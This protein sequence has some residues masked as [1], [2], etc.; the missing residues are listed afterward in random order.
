MGTARANCVEEKKQGL[1][2]VSKDN[3]LLNNN[4]TFYNPKN[5]FVNPLRLRKDGPT[6]KNKSY[7]IE[8]QTLNKNQQITAI[9]QAS[10]VNPPFLFALDQIQHELSKRKVRSS[11]FKNQL[12]ERKKLIIFSFY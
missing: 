8:K 2:F 9:Q 11:D 6:F 5:F 12:K 3:V 10:L 1:V 4:V 7:F